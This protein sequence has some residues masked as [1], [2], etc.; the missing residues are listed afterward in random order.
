MLSEVYKTIERKYEEKRNL[1]L[2]NF[3]LAKE[4]AY[5]SNP[6]LSEIDKEIAMLGIKSSRT[7]LVADKSQ[8]QDLLVEL[9]EKINT[10]KQEKEKIL[11]SMNAQLDIKYQCEKCKDTGY[12]IS[13]KG[14]E[15]CSCLKQELLDEA[16]N[17]SNLYSLKSDTF[18]NFNFELYSNTANIEK[19][20]VN[21]TP[22]QNIE[23]IRNLSMEF[24]ENFEDPNQKNLLFTGTPGVGKTFISSCIA[25]EILKKGYTVLYQ[26][27]PLLFDLIFEYKYGNKTAGSKELYDNILNVN[28]LVIDDLG[29]ENLT[30][31]RFAELFNILN[32][33]LLKP[34]VKTIISTNLSLEDLA[35]NYDDRILS[36]LIGNYSICRFFGDDIRL[37]K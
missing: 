32:A 36:R 20:G 2:H 14:S 13:E 23:K 33:R 12:I 6:R 26:T 7:A 10:L 25:N 22:R 29:T 17:K 11:A 19:Y 35:K 3:T 21:I 1:A 8:T 27:S 24:I 34:N 18:D 15:M 37:K 31:A 5:A 16:Y 30:A 4:K 9:S 28:L